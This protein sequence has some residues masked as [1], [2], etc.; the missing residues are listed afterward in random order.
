VAGDA[1][2]EVA[3]DA[4]TAIKVVED[5]LPSDFPGSIRESMRNGTVSRLKLM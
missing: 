1:L 3:R 2:A 5:Q 4:E